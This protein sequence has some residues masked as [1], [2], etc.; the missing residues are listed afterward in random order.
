MIS[1]E[2]LRRVRLFSELDDTELEEVSRVAQPRRFEK[3]QVIFYEQDPGDVC[4]V[5]SEG[6][7]KV[8]IASPEGK[9]IILSMLEA[10]DFFGEM[11]LFDDSPR[12]ATIVAIE[13]AEVWSIRRAE[14]LHL[15][16][17]NFSIARKVLAELSVRL[18][19][20]NLKIE[21][22]AHMD[23]NGRL[24]RYLMNLA[25]DSGKKL[26]NGYIAVVRPT[27]QEIANTI[28]TARETVSRLLHDLAERGVILS[29]GK[30][31]YIREGLL[32]DADPGA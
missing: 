7:V 1:K 20:A 24:A 10:G 12:S 26:G 18:R 30:T 2:L 3:D 29:E 31:V 13:A 5:I 21:S 23:V 17:E 15:L 19:R 11:A 14:F 32:G 4:F 9:E 16:S 25:R 28:G 22:L 6:K 27:H 8:T